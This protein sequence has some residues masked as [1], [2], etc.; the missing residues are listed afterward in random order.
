MP[1]VS[2][3]LGHQHQNLEDMLEMAPLFLQPINNC[4]VIFSIMMVKTDRMVHLENQ[5]VKE[6]MEDMVEP[7]LYLDLSIGG[8]LNTF[9]QIKELVVQ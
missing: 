8:F 9:L 4:L 7:I 5:L 1:V 6:E 2:K 3:V